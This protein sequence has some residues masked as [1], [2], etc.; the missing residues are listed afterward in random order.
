MPRNNGA[1]PKGRQRHYSAPERL[2]YMMLALQTSSEQVAREHGIT[3]STIRHWFA[4]AG[5]INEC[6]RWLEAETLGA[7]LRSR[8][9][10][11]QAVTERAPELGEEQLMETYRKMV[12]PAEAQGVNIHVTQQQAQG[13]DGRNVNAAEQAYI[14]TLRGQPSFESG[15]D[16][17]LPALPL[18]GNGTDGPL[19]SED[20]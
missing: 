15:S 16:G 11:F 6:R 10:I 2:G 20:S 14:A 8:Q 18:S 13:V 3:A 7:Y 1:K 4:D 19:P 5:G 12:T 9:A 17:S